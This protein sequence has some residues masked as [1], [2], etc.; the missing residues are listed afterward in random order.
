M[1]IDYGV[2]TFYLLKRDRKQEKRGMRNE[3]SYISNINTYYNVENY[4]ADFI[5]QRNDK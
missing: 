3:K 5:R 2:W 4:P 1:N